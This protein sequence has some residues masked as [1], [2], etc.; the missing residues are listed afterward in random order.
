[1]TVEF[2]VF[3]GKSATLYDPPMQR[4]V[5]V[6][7]SVTNG[8]RTWRAQRPLAPRY[9]LVVLN[10]RGFPPGPDVERVDFEDEAAWVAE[11]LRP[12]DHLAGH[13]YG[14]VVALLA[15]AASPELRSLVVVEPPALGVARGHPAVEAFVRASSAHWRDGPR[16]PAPFLR[17]FLGLVGS[18]LEPPSPLPPDLEQGARTLMV[19]RPP[20]E[21]E[22][23]LAR[24]RALPFPKLVVSGAHSAAFDAVCDALERG[25]RAERAV[26][27]GAGHA[28]QAAPGFN[29]V[30]EGFLRR[31]AEA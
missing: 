19:E 1:V 31:T 22:I 3:R 6:H 28:A 14:G 15:A 12:G 30:L 10:R 20:W 9:E 23:P 18:P 2:R 16:E 29:D 25:L 11:R 7:G 24:L 26:C 21:A 17:G 27:A 5:L 13:S 4:L 8:P